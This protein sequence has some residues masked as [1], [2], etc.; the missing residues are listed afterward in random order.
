MTIPAGRNGEAGANCP[1]VPTTVPF[2]PSPSIIG[3]REYLLENLEHHAWT[4]T[5]EEFM[6]KFDENEAIN[7]LYASTHFSWE[8]KIL[9]RF[10]FHIQKHEDLYILLF[11]SLENRIRRT[12]C[13][14]EW[15]SDTSY[16]LSA[17]SSEAFAKTTNLLKISNHKFDYDSLKYV[18]IMVKFIKSFEESHK[19]SNNFYM[20]VES[21]K[22]IIY[23]VEDTNNLIRTKITPLFKAS[24]DKTIAIIK[25]LSNENSRDIVIELAKWHS[26][27]SI[28]HKVG[29]VL[30]LI[31]LLEPVGISYLKSGNWFA[32]RVS[33]CLHEDESFKIVQPNDLMSKTSNKWKHEHLQLMKLLEYFEL[34]LNQSE[35]TDLTPVHSDIVALKSELNHAII[36][37][38]FTAIDATYEATNLRKSIE[39]IL[40]GSVSLRRYENIN[41]E[42]VEVK[43]VLVHFQKAL[44]VMKIGIGPN[45]LVLFEEEKL[46]IIC[47]VIDQFQGELNR[48]KRYEQAI[49]KKLLPLVTEPLDDHLLYVRA[50]LDFITEYTFYS[51]DMEVYFE[52]LYSAI[53]KV[54]ETSKNIASSSTAIT[55]KSKIEPNCD[56]SN[57]WEIENVYLKMHVASLLKQSYYNHIFDYFTATEKS[58]KQQYFPFAS[59]YLGSITSS[60]KKNSKSLFHSILENGH[61]LKIKLNSINYLKGFNRELGVRKCGTCKFYEWNLNDQTQINQLLNGDEVILSADIRNGLH[62]NAVKF[63]IISIYFKCENKEVENQLNGFGKAMDIKM[64]MIGDNFYRCNNRIFSIP[65]NDDIHLD[66]IR[67]NNKSVPANEA[68]RQIYSNS[69]YLSPFTDW[70]IK[71]GHGIDL[72]GP[73]MEIN[74]LDLILVGAGQYYINIGDFC[75]KDRLEEFYDIVNE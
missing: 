71:L 12:A 1:I 10:H 26:A 55:C 59:Y 21:I 51:R 6:E 57:I 75:D 35:L 29:S 34:I 39:M 32:Q 67:F 68:H 23:D 24:S 36:N 49:T 45:I 52:K 69:Y 60:Q 62:E 74:K 41:A 8:F 73:S 33:E 19:I 5:S 43:K 17:L 47:E 22:S 14:K 72:S 16:F 58:I 13:E 38:N 37:E 46:N 56:D 66:S 3:Y 70:K 11:R 30:E 27:S 64:T 50:H 15:P 48:W 25:K 4:S 40:N 28:V 53:D 63:G 42:K 44:K 9:E 18:E 7:C 65:M 31:G 54:I 2:N 61:H 20:A